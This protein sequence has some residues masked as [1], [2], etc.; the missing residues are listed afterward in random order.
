MHKL[1]AQLHPTFTLVFALLASACVDEFDGAN[2][3]IDFGPFVPNQARTLSL[4]PVGGTTLPFQHYR[5]YGIRDVTDGT[6][7]TMMEELTELQRFEIHRIVESDSPCFMDPKEARYPG[8]HV[9][10]FEARLKEE[11]GI[12]DITAPRPPGATEEDEIDV[13]TAIQRSENVLKL[14]RPA[15]LNDP[16]GS[17][18]LQ[19]DPGG[20]KA[21]TSASVVSYPAVGMLCVENGGDPSMIPPTNCRGDASNRA[22]LE[23]CQAFWDQAPEYYEGT[24]RVLTEPLAGQYYGIVIGENPVN[25]AVL[26]GT[27]F[28]VDDPAIGY[29]AFAIYL[30]FD[31]VNGDG[32]PDVPVGI[33]PSPTPFGTPLLRGV[34]RTQTRGVTRAFLTGA[35][36]PRAFFAD[37]TIFSDLGGD[38]VHF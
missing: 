6:G 9:T 30:Q 20:L 32:T 12:T 11:T 7:N 28:F 21:V 4:P 24:D 36:D 16:D 19:P 10:Q 35:S 18:P 26:G 1:K 2:I 31:D 33:P 3:Q 34:P 13:A 29:D 14:G 8:I 38:D 5:L 27:Q 37:L 17:G 15:N 25:R 22:R 23:A